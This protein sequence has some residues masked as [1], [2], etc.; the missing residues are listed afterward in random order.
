M[1]AFG[2]EELCEAFPQVGVQV[3]EAKQ[4][5]EAMKPHV[6]KAMKPQRAGVCGS[7]GCVSSL[8]E[9]CTSLVDTLDHTNSCEISEPRSV[10]SSKKTQRN[11][12]VKENGIR[13]PLTTTKTRSQQVTQRPV[14]N[15][16]QHTEQEEQKEEQEE[17]EEEGALQPLTPV[18]KNN[19][20][21]R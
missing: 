10:L 14:H 20:D 11:G 2:V 19:F 9:Y 3:V 1:E 4:T 17:Q 15:N 8:D 5:C 6:T 18:N 12:R 21:K 7:K 16:S 13:F